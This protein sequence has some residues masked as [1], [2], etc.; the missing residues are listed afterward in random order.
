MTLNEKIQQYAKKLPRPF[1]NELL[2]FVKYLVMKAEQH[3]KQE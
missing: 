3:E 1:Q 2:D